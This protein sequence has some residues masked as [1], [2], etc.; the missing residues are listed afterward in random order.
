MALHA[1]GVL[2]MQQG[3]YRAAASAWKES[4]SIWRAVDDRPHLVDALSYL[5]SIYRPGARAVRALLG[6]AVAVARE[7]GDPRRLA[8]SLG[9]FGWQL[10]QLDDLPAASAMLAEALPL[11][12]TP[13]DPWELIWMLYATGLLAIR[14]G[15][16]A[17]AQERFAETLQRARG[18]RDNMM[19]SLALAASGRYWL[20]EGDI[21]RA[22]TQFR[23]GLSLSRDAGFA[24][25]V[26]HHLEGIALVCHNRKSFE[27]AVRL[28]GAAEATYPL[29][30]VPGLVPYSSLVDQC[31]TSL[32][33]TLGQQRFSALF[34][35]GRGLETGEAVA[36]ALIGADGATTAARR[37]AYPSGS[38]T[39]RELEVLRLLAAG[40]SNPEI[41]S[42]LVLSVK[43]VERHLA[44]AYAKIGVRSRV[45]AATYVV[46]HDLR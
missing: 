11:A 39:A 46:T 32:R 33:E 4:I 40:Q 9:F 43:T 1:L 13:G 10:L 44:N 6:E 26:A 45:E 2:A 36:Q 12:R 22:G 8:L 21:D 20:R 5:G 28:L 7:L 16:T 38:L 27:A 23:E 31:V 34:A 35:D 25:G 29:I 41:A 17:L 3:D 15:D 42:A 30:D 24:I 19:A 14:E 37:A 18:A